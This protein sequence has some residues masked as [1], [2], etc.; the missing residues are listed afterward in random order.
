MSVN[1]T[2]LAFP[3]SRDYA[4][5][6][7]PEGEGDSGSSKA[8]INGH[9]RANSIIVRADP[10]FSQGSQSSN[11]SSSN[12]R[13]HSRANSQSQSHSRNP[14]VQTQASSK[15]AASAEKVVTSSIRA[16]VHVPTKDGHVLEF[17][18]LLTS[19]EE[20][21]DLPGIT[22]SAKK[23]AKQDMTLLIQSALAKWK[24]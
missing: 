1:G 18:P 9:K 14:S 3:K 24:I 5:S 12:I 6:N 4:D 8:R 2:P 17:D 11:S 20:L 13:T 23:Q 16:L 15:T 19:P 10:T 21:A 22:D 7:H